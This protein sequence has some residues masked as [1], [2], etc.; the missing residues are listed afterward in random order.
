MDW[1]LQGSHLRAWQ[2]IMSIFALKLKAAGILCMA[3]RLVDV[4]HSATSSRGTLEATEPKCL[5]LSFQPQPELKCL[6][7][8]GS[9]VR[10]PEPGKP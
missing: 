7:R 10:L 5:T 8:P 3:H 1:L 2:V 9:A 6:Y 4:T